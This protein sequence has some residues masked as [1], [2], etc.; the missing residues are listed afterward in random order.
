MG[1]NVVRTH[2]NDGPKSGPILQIAIALALLLAGSKSA[3][4]PPPSVK[5]V[6][7]KHPAKNRNATNMPKFWLAPHT[8]VNAT[9]KKLLT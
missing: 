8:A 3:I 9:K 1:H 2:P 7:P 5:G 4:V 6:A